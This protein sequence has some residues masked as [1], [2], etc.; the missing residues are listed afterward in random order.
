M[1]SKGNAF[2]WAV[3]VGT[4]VLL[5]G[6]TAPAQTS[7]LFSPYEVKVW[8]ALDRSWDA[9]GAWAGQIE[10]TVRDCCR[11]AAGA[12][13]RLEWSEPTPDVAAQMLRD[14]T[15]VSPTKIEQ[16]LGPDRLATLDKLILLAVKRL[17]EGVRVEACEWDV[18]TQKFGPVI[19]R[20]C[21]QSAAV[22]WTCG[23]AV[24]DAFRPL[25]RIDDVTGS[26]AILRFRAAGLAIEEPEALLARPEKGWV[27]SAVIRMNDRYGKPRPG[28]IRPV[29]WTLLVVRDWDGY[30]CRADVHTAN[31]AYLGFRASSRVDRFALVE[32]PIWPE[33]QLVLRSRDESERPLAGYDIYAKDPATE[34][35]EYLGQTDW[36]GQITIKPHEGRVRVLYVRSGGM[37]LARLPLLPGQTPVAVGRLTDDAKRLQAEALVRSLQAAVIDLI[38]QRELFA[39]RIR[40]LIREK[41]LDEAQRV[42]DQLRALPT[43]TDIRQRIDRGRQETNTDNPKIQAIIDKMFVDIQQFVVQR[44]DPRLIDRLAVELAQAQRSSK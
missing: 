43:V 15:G 24:L 12:T 9:D 31:R 8:L 39:A 37:L 35:T 36:R 30:K 25:A 2:G 1:T 18:R 10:R 22:P 6:R 21:L 19:A 16:L 5:A 7:W 11:M 26:T 41:N 42:L 38:A 3:V 27:L 40:F 20:T 17:P 23:Q 28:G 4:A 29:E 33:T 32:R 13:W 14:P 34:Q 44:L